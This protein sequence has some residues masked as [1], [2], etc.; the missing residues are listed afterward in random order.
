MP[1]HPNARPTPRRRET[2]V[3]RMESGEGVA[4]AA[5]Q[6]G[7]SRQTAGRRLRRSRAGVKKVARIPGGGHRALGRG[8]GVSC[9][10]V[11]VDDP[12]S[13][14]D[15][16]TVVAGVHAGVGGVGADPDRGAP[17][18]EVA[19]DLAEPC[20]PVV[21]FARRVVSM[22]LAV[23]KQRLDGVAPSV[24]VQVEPDLPLAS[25]DDR[26][27]SHDETFFSARPPPLGGPCAA[28]RGRGPRGGAGGSETRRARASAR[29]G[30]VASAR[31]V[32][33][34]LARPAAP[35]G[36]GATKAARGGRGR[37]AGWEG[38]CVGEEPGRRW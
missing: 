2:L 22:Q 27:V 36:H 12:P 11:A 3:S 10:H 32:F 31:K 1:R 30:R 4:E 25:G 37:E 20:P 24:P 28:C 8:A 33:A 23:P 5:R 15:V 26:P 14:D 18:E 21:V 13:L 29:L 17:A 7:V 34:A 16:D 19:D 9:L 6:M 38:G 35:P